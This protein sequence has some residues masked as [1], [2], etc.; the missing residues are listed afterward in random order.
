MLLL[1][2]PLRYCSPFL[3]IVLVNILIPLWSLGQSHIYMYFHILLTHVTAVDSYEIVIA[4]IPE[5][6]SPRPYVNQTY[7]DLLIDHKF[8]GGEEPTVHQPPRIFSAPRYR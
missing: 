1:F 4:K 6:P 5:L 2:F 7:T 3:A 8:P